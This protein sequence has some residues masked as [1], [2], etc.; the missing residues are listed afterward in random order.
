[1]SYSSMILIS[2]LCLIHYSFSIL[3]SRLRQNEDEETSSFRLPVRSYGIPSSDNSSYSNNDSVSEP[4]ISLKLPYTGSIDDSYLIVEENGMITNNVSIRNSS[5]VFINKVVGPSNATYFKS[6]IFL[7]DGAKLG[8]NV[9]LNKSRLFISDSASG[10]DDAYLIDTYIVLYG[11]SSSGRWWKVNNSDLEFNNNSKAL[12]SF[13]ATNSKLE[14]KGSSQAAPNAVYLNSEIKFCERSN[15]NINAT[16]NNSTVYG[17]DNARLPNFTIIRNSSVIRQ[18]EN[19]KTVITNI[20]DSTQF[21][22][23]TTAVE[24]I[25]SRDDSLL[26]N[27]A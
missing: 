16:I 22:N 21:L 5:L 20:K 11:K 9:T 26:P 27:I 7:Y 1:M 25:K 19:S 17:Y 2:M 24:A 15:G 8:K 4:E 13:S 6:T 14:F 23:K 3:K 10:P 12:S 18:N